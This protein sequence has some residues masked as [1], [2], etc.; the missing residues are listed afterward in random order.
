DV[1]GGPD[2]VIAI[3]LQGHIVHIGEVEPDDTGI[4]GKLGYEARCFRPCPLR[5]R[6]IGGRNGRWCWL[7][8]GGAFCRRQVSLH[9]VKQHVERLCRSIQREGEFS[10]IPG[11]DEFVP[12]SELIGNRGGES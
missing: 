11:D 4:G 10:S 6:R 9:A 3:E 8:A 2:R 1:W 7:F 5:P 12:G